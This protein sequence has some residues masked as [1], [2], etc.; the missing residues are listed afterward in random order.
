MLSNGSI[1]IG[2]DGTHQAAIVGTWYS[3]TSYSC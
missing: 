2:A 1:A 3:R